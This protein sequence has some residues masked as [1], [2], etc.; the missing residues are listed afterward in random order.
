MATA[1]SEMFDRVAAMSG[2]QKTALVKEIENATRGDKWLPNEGQQTEAYFS[3]ADVLLYGGSAGGGKTHL[4]LGWGINEARSGIIFRREGTQ[5]DG[6]EKEGK[7]VIGDDARFNGVDNEWL[8]PESAK[9]FCP[10]LD[11]L[12][13]SPSVTLTTFA[14][15]A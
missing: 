10:P 9:E 6:L 7:L 14:I 1:L 5:T 3:K 4:E 8:S 11:I 15:Q 13:V 12:M 2:D